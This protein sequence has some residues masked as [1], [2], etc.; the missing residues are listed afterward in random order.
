LL[1]YEPPTDSAAGGSGNTYVTNVEFNVMLEGFT[2]RLNE[3]TERFD[4]ML[5]AAANKEDSQATDAL[6]DRISQLME[7]SRNSERAIYEARRDRNNA[8][9]ALLMTSLTIQVQASANFFKMQEET[10][11]RMLQSMFRSGG[12]GALLRT[13][14]MQSS[15]G[16]SYSGNRLNTLA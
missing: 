8:R 9:L 6:F 7:D 5:A 1:D 10:M 4:E 15:F 11:M 3:L 16:D 13:A 12:M 14:M 2:E